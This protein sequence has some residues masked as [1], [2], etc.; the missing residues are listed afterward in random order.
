MGAA[1]HDFRI[2]LPTYAISGIKAFPPHCQLSKL[3]EKSIQNFIQKTL[4]N[5]WQHNRMNGY[6]KGFGHSKL[7]TTDL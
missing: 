2:I 4:K 7:K 3:R 1:N 6:T 5:K